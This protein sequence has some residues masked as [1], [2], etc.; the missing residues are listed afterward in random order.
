MRRCLAFEPTTH[1]HTHDRKTRFSLAS[2]NVSLLLLVFCSLT[3]PA[4]SHTHTANCRSKTQQINSCS[5]RWLFHTVA[6]TLVR[7]LCGALWFTMIEF[8]IDKKKTKATRSILRSQGATNQIHTAR[9]VTLCLRLRANRAISKFD[10][11]S[12]FELFRPNLPSSFSVHL[13]LS[14][15][16]NRRSIYA[17]CQ[18]RR[19]IRK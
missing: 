9:I 4:E 16:W 19:C 13:V 17:I 2:P 10:N 12:A 18:G 8:E 11:E 5:M 7:F 14:D 6:V 3:F 15:W 1:T